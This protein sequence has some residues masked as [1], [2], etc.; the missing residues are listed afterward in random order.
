MKEQAIQKIN[1]MGKIGV[2]IVTIMKVFVI[3]GIVGVLIGAVVCSL[4]PDDLVSMQFSGDATVTIN[5]EA[6]EKMTGTQIS[7][8]ELRDSLAASGQLKM[9]GKEYS[10]GEIALEGKKMIV[11][12]NAESPRSIELGNLAGVWISALALLAA[13]LVTL[14]F[15]GRLCKAFR[16]C[17]TPFEENVIRKM[18][19]LAYALIPWIILNSVAAAVIGFTLGRADGIDISFDPSVILIVLVVFAL[20]YVFRYG[21]MLQQE[22][23]ETL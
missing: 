7:E 12:A 10:M 14:I 3:I 4:L 2:I 19:Q 21:A 23:D 16:D 6:V 13:G 8:Q 5:M 20:V 18:Q 22:A 9:D 17:E 11:D 15:A 1:K